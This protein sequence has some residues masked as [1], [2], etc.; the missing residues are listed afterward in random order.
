MA[1]GRNS[2]VCNA[3]DEELK[4]AI[5][6]NV[7]QYQVCQHAADLGLSYVLIVYCTPGALPKK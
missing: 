1:E 4:Q 3:G 2:V 7:Y 6:E 5:P